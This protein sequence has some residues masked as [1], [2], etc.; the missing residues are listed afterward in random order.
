MPCSAIAYW[1]ICRLMTP[2]DTQEPDQPLASL[3]MSSDGNVVLE[4]LAP[5]IQELA[6]KPGRI[7][8]GDIDMRIDPKAT[9]IYRGSPIGRKE[10]VTLFSTVLHLDDFGQYWMI[11]PAEMARINVEDAPFT[12]LELITSGDGED[13]SIEFRTNV[14]TVIPL[15]DE[16]PL[17]V[18]H[19][20]ETGEPRPYITVRG[21]LD[22]L[23]VRSVFYQLVEVGVEIDVDGETVLGVWSNGCFFP[24]GPAGEEP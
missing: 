23:I 12:A 9:W 24:I 8:C 15:D 17:K 1:E 19:D 13:M 4:D 18:L 3:N 16:H 2:T 7:M 21:K 14:D 11:T 10:M 6:K 5:D 22:A 20:K